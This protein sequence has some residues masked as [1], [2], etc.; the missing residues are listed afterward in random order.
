MLEAVEDKMFIDFVRK[1]EQ[2]V[3]LA[4]GGIGYA[5]DKELIEVSPAYMVK[6]TKELPRNRVLKPDEIGTFWDVLG[7]T[8][9][10]LA[11]QLALRF[12]LITGQRRAEVVE[13]SWPEIDRP[14]RVWEIPASRT[15][16]GRPHV[17]PLTDMALDMLDQIEAASGTG[18]YLF[19][20]PLRP[21]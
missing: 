6:R 16:K 13:A 14:E 3:F 2:I 18:P 1:N 9:I 12:L 21:G 19:P 17:V 8:D 10:S 4:K 20:S 7:S 15:K 11:L 5:L